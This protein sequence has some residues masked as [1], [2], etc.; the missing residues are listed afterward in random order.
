MKRRH[1]IREYALFCIIIILGAVLLVGC[2]KGDKG[3]RGPAGP[4]G[5]AG[6]AGPAGT[7]V[8]TTATSETCGGA[9]LEQ[10]PAAWKAFV[11]VKRFW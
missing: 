8:T 1:L 5:P 7:N 9:H 6:P 3:D 11:H 10:L 4:T 2:N